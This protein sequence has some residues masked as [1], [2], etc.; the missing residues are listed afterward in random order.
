MPDKKPE[1]IIA[2]LKARIESLRQESANYRIQRNDALKQNSVLRT[3]VSK[4]NISFD[5]ETADVSSLKIVDGKVEG[6]FDYTPAK[7]TSKQPDMKSGEK[8]GLSLEDI[9]AMS[10]EEINKRWDEV[11]KVL[12]QEE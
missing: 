11:S 1:E 2:E 7:P 5:L 3:V 12:A 6:E 4:H 8:Q 10:E 9:S